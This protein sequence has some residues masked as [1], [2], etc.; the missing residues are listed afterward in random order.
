MAAALLV[1]FGSSLLL[2]L[3]VTPVARALALRLQLVDRPDD[4]KTHVRT[5]PLG[6]GLAILVSGSCVLGMALL[7]PGPAREILEPQS[8]GLL[9][10]LLAALVICA[11][12][13]VDDGMRLRAAAKFCGQLLAIAVAIHFSP[14]VRSVGLFGWELDLGVFAVPFTA[15]WLLG[16]INSLNLLDGMDGMLT[17]VGLFIS[18]AL[19]V[20]AVLAGQWAA[21][22]VAATLAG[23]LLGFLRYNFPPATIFL[24]DTGSML[25]GLVVGMLALRSSLKGPATIGLAVPVALL[26]L[27]FLDTL[28]AI[29]RRKLKG[30]S[31][32]TPDR[33]HLHHCLLRRGLSNRGVLLWVSLLSL[34]T[35]AGALA[36]L[37]FNHEFF[38]IVSVVGVVGTLV[39]A[40]LFGHAELALIRERLVASA[41]LLWEVGASGGW[42]GAELPAEGGDKWK[43]LWTTLKSRAGQLNLK[44]IRLHVKG[45]GHLRG[46]HARWACPE[47]RQPGSALWRAEIPLTVHGQDLGR[48]EVAGERDQKSVLERMTALARLVEEFEVRHLRPM[49]TSLKATPLAVSSPSFGATAGAAFSDG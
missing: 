11:V 9:G 4:R 37:A 13:L 27:P 35:G 16:T 3:L 33:G 44:V 20:M 36:S 49:V 23:S 12:G 39:A 14:V 25:I 38:A 31:M 18:G 1:L 7:A 24:G 47:E 22:C 40:R 26:T 19:A 46:Y 42:R 5:T 28:A 29:I 21:A 34:V 8:R 30:L 41:G 6:G 45:S 43:E 48:L 2:C 15:L 17:C 32:S 10:L